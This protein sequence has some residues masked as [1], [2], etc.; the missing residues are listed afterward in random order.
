MLWG[1]SSARLQSQH[2]WGGWVRGQPRLHSK[3]KQKWYVMN[4]L[5]KGDWANNI[6]TRQE[7]KRKALARK[8]R[9]LLLDK[10]KTSIKKFASKGTVEAQPQRLS[11]ARPS[12]SA[13]AMGWS[14]YSVLIAFA[15]ACPCQ[16][17][18]AQ[19][20]FEH[21]AR[22]P[23]K[24]MCHFPRLLIINVWFRSV[25]IANIPPADFIKSGG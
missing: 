12:T 20:V 17:R 3:S 9:P 10:E 14:I 4:Y 22:V 25:F 19:P 7:F 8:N 18:G 21:P 11:L 16:D 23:W 2:S 1:D 5:S 13:M 15:L 24:H 6:D